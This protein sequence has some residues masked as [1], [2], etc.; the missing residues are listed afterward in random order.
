MLAEITE[1]AQ[2]R[3]MTVSD[4]VR[5]R[6]LGHPVVDT[7]PELVDELRKIRGAANRHAGLFKH[8]Y[9]VN[10]NYSKETAEAL[11]E[12]QTLYAAAQRALDVIIKKRDLEK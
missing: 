11:H 8:L 5:R 1:A 3:G 7:N 6:V 12:A 10:H 4:Y 2:S 9:N